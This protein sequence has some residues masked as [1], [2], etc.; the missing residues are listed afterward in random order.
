MQKLDES[1]V[2]LGILSVEEGKEKKKETV[3][4]PVPVSAARMYARRFMVMSVVGA[5]FLVL[6][7]GLWAD[8]ATPAVGGGGFAPGGAASVM[9]L[10]LVA[11]V[12]LAVL[13][14]LGLVVVGFSVVVRNILLE[15]LNGNR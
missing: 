1:N 4:A 7:W 10:L 13:G 2:G 14:V 3:A 11:G 6:A 5:A 9:L 12:P 8:A 15:S